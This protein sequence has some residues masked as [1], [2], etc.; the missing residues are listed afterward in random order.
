MPMHSISTYKLGNNLNQRDVIAVRK[1]VSALIKL[2][3]PHG[4][5][6]KDDVEE[7]L[8]FALECRRRV[9]EQLKRIGG[10]E[11]Y[12]VNF[13]YIDNESFCRRICACP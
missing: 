7:I 8:R 1:M 2:I 9:K 10:M 12:D 4:K 5:F 11:F 3:Y 13:S 6:E